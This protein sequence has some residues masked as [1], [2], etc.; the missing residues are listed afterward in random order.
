MMKW[1]VFFGALCALACSEDPTGTYRVAG[2]TG[3][4]VSADDAV[5]EDPALSCLRVNTLQLTRYDFRVTEEE[6]RYL[7]HLPHGCTLEVELQGTA[8][9]AKNQPCELD[10]E[11]S[12]ALLGVF[13]RVFEEFH[14]EF[15]GPPILRQR[16]INKMRGASGVRSNCSNFTGT[17]YPVVEEAKQ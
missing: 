6:G 5:M 16:A 2:T 17:A 11:G 4:F 1:V 9:V 13:E 10:P 14:L 8:L 3:S 12:F 7:A 15:K